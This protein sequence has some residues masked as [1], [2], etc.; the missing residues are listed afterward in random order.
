[1]KDIEYIYIYK[2]TNWL[3]KP[4][5]RVK[6]AAARYLCAYIARSSFFLHSSRYPDF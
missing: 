3:S 4:L 1:M 5:I 6:Y 2:E